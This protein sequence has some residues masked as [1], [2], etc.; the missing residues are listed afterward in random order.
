MKLY[1]YS[2]QHYSELRTL[3][4]Q[5][6]ISQEE[7]KKAIEIRLS[8]LAPGFYYEHISFFFDP[9]PYE[10]LGKIFGKDHHTWFPGSQLFEY[11]IDVKQL[12]HFSYFIVE[13]PEKTELFYNQTISDDE[14]DVRIKEIIEEHHY[15]GQG[16]KAFIKASE[17]LIGSTRDYYLKIK[18]RPNWNDIKNKYAA[19]VPHVMVYPDKGIVKYNAVKEV[20]IK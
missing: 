2:K 18:S 7:K 1:H 14:Y 3:E 13:T 8:S 16:E 11:E 17:P 10:A 19:T 5:R 20:T 12:G 15:I 6:P 9:V 4:K